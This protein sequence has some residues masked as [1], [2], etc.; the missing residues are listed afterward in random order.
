MATVHLPRSLAALFPGIPRRLEVPGTTVE[1][2][3]RA[4]DAAWPGAWERV[5]EPGPRV[6]PHIN[7]FV[8]GRR[9]ELSEPVGPAGVVHIIPAVSGG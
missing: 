7:L 4:L 5:C 1:E 2:V 3:L 8:D 9:A 6:R